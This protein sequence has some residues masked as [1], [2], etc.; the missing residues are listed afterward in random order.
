MTIGAGRMILQD[1]RLI[2]SEIANGK[3]FQNP[4]LLKALAHAEKNKSNLHIMGILSD[5]RIHQDVAHMYA[6]LEMA[7]N[8]DIKNIYVHAFPDGRDCPIKSVE[9]YVKEFNEKTKG[10]IIFSARIVKNIAPKKNGKVPLVKQHLDLK[11]ELGA[12]IR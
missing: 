9:K 1:L 8:F 12:N 7:K 5:G 11:K 2:D 6:I 10:Q 3:F 4:A